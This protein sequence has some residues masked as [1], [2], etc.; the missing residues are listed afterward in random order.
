LLDHKHNKVGAVVDPAP[1]L[2]SVGKDISRVA[3]LASMRQSASVGLRQM[4]PLFA[5]MLMGACSAD[6]VWLKPR[7]HELRGEEWAKAAALHVWAVLPEPPQWKKDV[8]RTG[9]KGTA[10]V[11][12]EGQFLTA[13]TLVEDDRSVGLA[14]VNKY[15]VAELIG[16]SD[17]GAC[18]LAADDPPVNL[19]EWRRTAPAPGI[20]E[21]AILLTSIDQDE[22]D[23]QTTTI[24]GDRF[25]A[26]PV[27]GRLASA[28][29][30][31][32]GAVIG[33][34]VVETGGG[35]RLIGSEALAW[36]DLARLDPTNPGRSESNNERFTVAVDPEFSPPERRP[37]ASEIEPA[38]GPGE[39]DGGPFGTAI[40]R[41]EAVL[42]SLSSS[43]TSDR[44]QGRKAAGDNA[45]RESRS[46]GD[47]RRSDQGRDDRGR[48][49]QDRNDRDGENRGRSKQDRD[50]QGRDDQDR[51]NRGRGDRDRDDK[52]RSDQG[53]NNRGGNE[54]GRGA[55]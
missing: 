17:D 29:F 34:A 13:C 45:S 5:A 35:L 20:A 12:G 32:F 10:V 53:R 18:L 27:D 14:R 21:P 15:Y 3:R 28:A 51:N 33:I 9:I 25:K 16:R 8:T 46:Q 30:D 23:A 36:T 24:V 39:S 26:G 52:G 50:D 49:E 54:K 7:P 43:V 4:G 40:D 6:P 38:A 41:I 47:Q 37:A 11:V 22:I 42:T 55:A 31:R 19:P 44:N 48:N 2:R 1:Y